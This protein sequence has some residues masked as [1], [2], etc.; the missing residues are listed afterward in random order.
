MPVVLHPSIDFDQITVRDPRGGDVILY[1]DGGAIRAYKNRCPHV[2]VGLDWGNGRC[3]SA[4]NELM[5]AVHGARFHADSGECF[6]GPCAGDRLT[7]VLVR[8]E[9]GQIVAEDLPAS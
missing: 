3:L 2:G 6:S 8:V 4:P 7:P 9:A 1:N 5:C